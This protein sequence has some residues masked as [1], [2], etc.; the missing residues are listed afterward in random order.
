MGS[1]DA[2]ADQKSLESHVPRERV[3][4]ILKKI[5][6]GVPLKAKEDDDSS[7]DKIPRTGRN[8]APELKPNETAHLMAPKEQLHDSP[9]YKTWTDPDQDSADFDKLGCK[10]DGVQESQ[11]PV[12]EEEDARIKAERQAVAEWQVRQQVRE[13]S[14]RERLVGERLERERLEQERQKKQ[15]A[16]EERCV[17]GARFAQCTSPKRPVA[18]GV[19]RTSSGSASPSPKGRDEFQYYTRDRYSNS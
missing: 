19:A 14:E 6:P 4:K 12:Q 13:K 18:P 17:F 2:E 3:R 9:T 11:R 1:E 8:P 16:D 10:A 15:E 5:H 7:Y